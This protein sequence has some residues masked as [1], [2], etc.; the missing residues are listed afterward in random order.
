MSSDVPFDL[1]VACER[2]RSARR[3]AEALRADPHLHP[4]A[5]ERQLDEL[6]VLELRV[7]QMWRRAPRPHR[8]V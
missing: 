8:P 5:L 7:R 6:R 1:A 4:D 2:L 3:L